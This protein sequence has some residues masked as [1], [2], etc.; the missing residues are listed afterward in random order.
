MDEQDKELGRIVRE[1]SEKEKELACLIQKRDKFQTRIDHSL[2]K[3]LYS[4]KTITKIDR[5]TLTDGEIQIDWLDG[6]E[7]VQMSFDIHRLLREVETAKR[8]LKMMGID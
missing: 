2:K 7:V 5:N 1:K 6:D 4:P 3:L 8:N